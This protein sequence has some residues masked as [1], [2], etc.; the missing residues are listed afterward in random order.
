[1]QVFS[2]MVVLI[3][4]CALSESNAGSPTAGHIQAKEYMYDSRSV[5][6][7]QVVVRGRFCG[8]LCVIGGGW[9][10]A[11]WGYSRAAPIFPI[12]LSVRARRGVKGSRGQTS[13]LLER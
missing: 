10:G 13:Q 8:V 12:L 6:S 3:G 11:P 9:A 7:L 4:C 5:V 2:F 1:M